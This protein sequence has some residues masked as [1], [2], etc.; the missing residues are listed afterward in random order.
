[1]GRIIE[2]RI[3]LPLTVDEYKIGQLYSVAEA[4]RKETGGGDGVEIRENRPFIREECEE[5]G[6]SGQYTYKIMHLEHK[7]PKF[8]TRLGLFEP[9]DLQLHEKAWN[10]YPYCKTVYSNS[11]MK[12]DFHIIITTWHRI[13]KDEENVHKLDEET[14]KEREIVNIDIADNSLFTGEYNVEEDPSKFKSEKTGRGPLKEGWIEDS[15][16]QPKMTCYKIYDIKFKLWGFQGAVECSIARAVEKLLRN[17][18]R[19][20]FCWIDK[21]FGLTMDDIRYLEDET[22]IAL[23]KDRENPEFKVRGI[24]EAQSQK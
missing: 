8:I 21:W 19:E 23:D 5:Y 2:Y 17:F 1:M 6:S 15:S 14:L 4:S 3:T 20:V 7:L 22:K 9:Q 11:W 12:N 18:H 16:I 24:F 10:A 13:G